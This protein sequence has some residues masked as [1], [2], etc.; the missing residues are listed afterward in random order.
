[1]HGACVHVW[2][3]HILI[4]QNLAKQQ[5]FSKGK[6][7]I[8]SDPPDQ[9]ICLHRNSCASVVLSHPE[10]SNPAKTTAIRKDEIF[11]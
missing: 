4:L 2:F 8:K 7:F 10:S 11:I 1:M 9:D 3:S 5:P 6:I